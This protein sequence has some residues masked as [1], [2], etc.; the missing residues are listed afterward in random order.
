MRL[1]GLPALAL[2]LGCTLGAGFF[3]VM[4][5]WA[6]PRKAPG[7]DRS[8]RQFLRQHSR[9]ITLAGVSAIVG[10]MAG[11]ITFAMSGIV[12]LSIVLAF[13][14]AG[15][16]QFLLARQVNRE[17]LVMRTMWP[18]VVDS[19]VS[20]LRAGASLPAAVSSL[21]TL[22]PRFV[23]EAAVVF[24][25]Q[26]QRSG[27]FDACLNV[28]KDTWADPA[29]D[30]II[31]ALRL[32]RHVGGSHVTTVL[33]ALG[34]YLRKESAI[35]QEVEARQGWIRIAARIGV[36]APWVVLALLSTRPEAAE[37]YNSPAGMAVIFFGLGLCFVAYRIM[38][39]VGILPQPKR[40][41]A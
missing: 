23:A 10:V 30:R 20:A 28:M 35:R 22:S 9:V 26:F 21:S 36:A 17:R 7:R 5:V 3:L 37:A 38:R 33:R 25:R 4:S 16:P 2:L 40:W 34:G 19:L 13:G 29:A 39:A 1:D 11:A 14:A 31:E 27:N 12:G 24:E 8:E 18:D 32:A 6:W 15:V 41:F